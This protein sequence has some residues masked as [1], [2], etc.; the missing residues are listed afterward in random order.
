[1]I[2]VM[3]TGFMNGSCLRKNILANW[4]EASS[5]QLRINQLISTKFDKNQLFMNYHR[6]YWLNNFLMMQRCVQHGTEN[7]SWPYI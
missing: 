3:L 6:V 5:M 1:M 7:C 2:C 4:Q